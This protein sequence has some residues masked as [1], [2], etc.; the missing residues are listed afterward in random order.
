MSGALRSA[1]LPVTM[2]APPFVE[3][4]SASLRDMLAGIR[5]GPRATA[6]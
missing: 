6:L 3:A 2:H 4:L 5:P 1:T